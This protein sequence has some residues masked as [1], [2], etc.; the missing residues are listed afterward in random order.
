[1][2][3][4]QLVLPNRCTTFYLQAVAFF[5]L[6]IKNEASVSSCSLYIGQILMLFG[7]EKKKFNNIHLCVFLYVKEQYTCSSLCFSIIVG[8]TVGIRAFEKSTCCNPL[9][10]NFAVNTMT[11]LQVA[12]G[13]KKLNHNNYNTWS[14]CI[15]SYM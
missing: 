5:S 7:S 13:M 14:T 9:V 10:R 15:M 2:E 3:K 1:M 6:G 11:N 8:F 4:V 12:S